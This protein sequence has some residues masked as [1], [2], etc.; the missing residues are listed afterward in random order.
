MT[1]K[2]RA[3]YFRNDA[4]TIPASHKSDESIFSSRIAGLVVEM[5][6]TEFLTRIELLDDSFGS[7]YGDCTEDNANLNTAYD[8]GDIDGAVAGEHSWH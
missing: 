3:D 2:V 1:T 8:F 6:G 7:W 4:V 5:R